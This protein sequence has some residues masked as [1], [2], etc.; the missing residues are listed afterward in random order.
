MERLNE[1]LVDYF[2]MS[3]HR[4]EN[5]DSDANFQS[6]ERCS[7]RWHR[8]TIRQSLSQRTPRTRNKLDAL[9]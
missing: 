7:I 2:L 6:F 3:A 9:G 8:S 4:E 1:K 5:I